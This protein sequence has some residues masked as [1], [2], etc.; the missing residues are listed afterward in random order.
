MLGTPV[1]GL[2]SQPR[3]DRIIMGYY[4][5]RQEHV[6]LL[7]DD[8]VNVLH[9]EYSDAEKKDVSRA[10]ANLVRSRSRR[11]VR[12]GEMGGMISTVA[13]TFPTLLDL[14]DLAKWCASSG[15]HLKQAGGM[16]ALV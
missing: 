4:L 15:V 2:R 1:A 5:Y 12:P 13:L 9:M 7:D 14:G 10:A 11:L 16:D 3:A 6:F 8:K